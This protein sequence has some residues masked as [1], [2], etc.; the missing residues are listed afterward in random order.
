MKNPGTRPVERAWLLGHP[1]RDINW[2][3]RIIAEGFDIHHL[4][5]NRFNNDSSNLILLEQLDHSMIHRGRR[6]SISRVTFQSAGIQRAK[7]EGKYKGRKPLSEDHIREIA[8][9]YKEAKELGI[10]MK[11]LSKELGV[12]RET[13]R[14]YK[15][16]AQ[17]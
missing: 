13:V 12:S 3:K 2:L 14:K 8:D 17:K 5:G 9:R 16:I 10:S 6:D 7:K 4:D 11:Q 15:E 1:E